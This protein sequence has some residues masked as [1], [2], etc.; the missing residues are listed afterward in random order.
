MVEYRAAKEEQL[1]RTFQALADPS[2]RQIVALLREADELKVTDIA[3]AFSMSLNGVSKHLK[4]LE[5]AGI[6]E[7]RIDGREHWLRVRWEALQAPY[8]WLHFYHHFWSERLDALVD[9]VTT[10][11]DKA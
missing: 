7:R 9:Y 6:L 3:D 11:G 8:E 10:K 5:R 1:S 2:R 4:V